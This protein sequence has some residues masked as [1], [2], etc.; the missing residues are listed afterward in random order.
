MT[1]TKEKK[2]NIHRTKYI[3]S[4]YISSNSSI[5]HKSI[6]N[7]SNNYIKLLTKKN[8]SSQSSSPYN[9][10][11]KYISTLAHQFSKSQ[12]T[13]LLSL[14]KIKKNTQFTITYTKVSLKDSSDSSDTSDTSDSTISNTYSIPKFIDIFR[15]LLTKNNYNNDF[16][17][18]F[19]LEEQN[20]LKDKLSTNYT[21]K[22]CY[23]F[24]DTSLLGKKIISIYNSIINTSIINDLEMK[25]PSLKFHRLL[26]NSFTSY[27]ILEDLELN[28]KTLIQYSI[29]YEG[30][31]LE[32]VVYL[33]T[34]DNATTKVKH[35]SKYI[36]DLGTDI[37]KR[38]LF[39]NTFLNTSHYPDKFI[40][41]LTD[42]K[43]EIDK[44]LMEHLH[45]RTI[46]V[47]TAVTDGSDIIIYREQELFKSIFHEL[48]HFHNLDFRHVSPD[49]L[50]NI[51][52]YLIKTHNIKKNNEYLLYECITESLANILNNIYYSGTLK[53]MTINLENEIMFSTLQTTK[54][55][56]ICKY[57]KWSDFTQG[58]DNNNTSDSNNTIDNKS[59]QFKQDSCVFSYYILKLYIFLNLD[60]YFKHVL[61]SK[62]KFIQ[63]KQ[64]FNYLI[65]IF[66]SSRKNILLEN[67][68][69][70]ILHGLNLNLNLNKHKNKYRKKKEINDIEDINLTLRMTCL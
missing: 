33:F 35:T 8:T 19:N 15:Y 14:F 48:I 53:E 46:N 41:F 40:L 59:K 32:N 27:K 21:K 10:Y 20:I 22:Q 52:S 9:K 7:N 25:Y 2:K 63:T 61:D 51:I 54:I 45:F 68:V 28:I 36:I 6:C 64:S 50:N 62:M 43:K 58:N 42:N 57:K 17:N 56:N 18:K 70:S 4:K 60:T 29:V 16:F 34:Y 13:L 5:K 23:T 47:N 30:K 24:L 65:K 11:K 38:I 66:D 67:M 44:E 1:I 31:T 49:I 37:V 12:N 3:R 39:F 26:I 55:L 69:N